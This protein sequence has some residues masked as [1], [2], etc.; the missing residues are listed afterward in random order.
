MHYLLNNFLDISQVL[1]TPYTVINT[2]KK[3]TTSHCCPTNMKGMD[4]MSPT[5]MYRGSCLRHAVNT[6]MFLSS[7]TATFRQ[8]APIQVSVPNTIVD[9]LYY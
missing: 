3:R 4:C 7:W 6:S 1:I 9:F 8:T 2:P 5:D